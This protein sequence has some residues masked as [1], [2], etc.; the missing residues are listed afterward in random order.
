MKM[1]AIRCLSSLVLA[2]GLTA[3]A[4]GAYAD[5]P[6]RNCFAEIVSDSSWRILH[7]PHG[8]AINSFPFEL[9]VTNRG[10]IDCNGR[11]RIR[12]DD[13][14]ARLHNAETGQY[15]AY[16]MEDA[17]TGFDVT[18]PEFASRPIAATLRVSPN[19]V[20][21]NGYAVRVAPQGNPGAGQF[22]QQVTFDYI[23]PNSK[24]VLASRTIPIIYEVRA[25]AR[26][27]LKGEYSRIGGIRTIS[28]GELEDRTYSPRTVVTVDSTRSYLLNVRSENQGRLV[29]QD[30]AWKIPY[31]LRMGSVDVDLSSPFQFQRNSRH[32]V[33][34][35]YPLQFLVQDTS[36]KRAGRYSDILHFTVTAI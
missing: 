13:N 33:N 29:H 34:D 18:P 23:S 10:N 26:I 21:A 28:L 9:R 32:A 2:L 19:G 6:E 3:T 15:I 36:G 14:T 8:S 27:G 35:E 1:R 20:A 31:R 12:T 4:T 17:R 11:I 22:I 25:S 5:R 7:D 16:D 24:E 30:P